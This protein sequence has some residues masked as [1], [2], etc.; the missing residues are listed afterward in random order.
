MVTAFFAI[1]LL[2]LVL[3]TAYIAI[4]PK[5]GEKF[6][7]FYLLGPGGKADNYPLSYALG[8][9]KPIIVGISNHEY[10]NVTYDLVVA[11][12]DSGN[13]TQIYAG[14]YSLVNNQTLE[15]TIML[16]PDH[17]GEH[18]RMEFWLYADG[19]MTAPYRELYLQVSVT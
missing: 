10:R 8:D 19:N 11:L 2:A 18:M 5:Q 12:N 6:T 3:T 1:L 9:Q 14:N 4:M 15:K 13:F 17:K 7:E 16:K